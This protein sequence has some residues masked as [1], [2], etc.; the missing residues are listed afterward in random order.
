M[1]PDPR[2][3]E[4]FFSFSS[5]AFSGL[6]AFAIAFMNG[7]QGLEGWSWIFVRVSRNH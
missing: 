4:L 2:V 5:G 6:L 3:V 7:T 1:V